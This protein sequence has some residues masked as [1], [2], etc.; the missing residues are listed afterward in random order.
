MSLIATRFFLLLCSILSAGIC[1]GQPANDDCTGFYDLDTLPFC[2]GLVF[3]NSNAL[4]SAISPVNIPSCFSGSQA[5]DDVWFRFVASDTIDDYEFTISGIHN[6]SD[7]AMVNPHITLYRGRCPDNMAELYCRATLDGSNTLKDNLLGLTRGSV[8]Y[9]RV[10]TDKTA[11]NGA[12][13][14]CIR[15]KPVILSIDEGMTD[16]CSG[17]LYD[18]GGETGNYAN[19]ENF[20]FLIC[21][22]GDPACIRLTVDYYNLEGISEFK[23]S[24]DDLRIYKGKETSGDLLYQAPGFSTDSYGAVDIPLTAS[25]SCVTVAFSS[26]SSLTY[27]GFRITWECSAT[28]CETPQTFT[29]TA[30]ENQD[31]IINTI[32][33]ES[34]NLKLTNIKC[35]P[36]AYGLF[37]DKELTLG[38][39]QGLLMTTG[40]AY[41]ARGSNLH[42]NITADLGLEG[43]PDLDKLSQLSGD[44]VKSF[45]ACVLEFEVYA[46]TDELSFDYVFGSDEYP[47]FVDLNYN[48]IFAFLISGPGIA[49]VPELNNQKNIA[50]I[51]LSGLPVEINSVNYHKNWM[52]YKEIPLLS[53]LTEYDGITVNMRKKNKTFTA[54]SKVIP[55]NTYKLKLAIADR[56]DRDYD[57]GVFISKIKGHESEI[58][59]EGKLK[60]LLKNCGLSDGKVRITLQTPAPEDIT[61]NVN[62]SGS[63]I[64]DVDYT[65][66]LGS[67][68][69]FLKN[70]E[71]LVFDLNPIFD[72]NDYQTQVIE[73]I[74]SR[75]FGCGNVIL[76]KKEI[77][78]RGNPDIKIKNKTTGDTLRIC[79][80]DTIQLNATDIGTGSYVWSP[81]IN[82]SGANI[83]NPLC[84]PSSPGWYYVTGTLNGCSSRDSVYIVPG[85]PV[86][87]LA[88][89]LPGEICGLQAF[90]TKATATYPGGKFYWK[91]DDL[92]ITNPYNESQ[93]F[94]LYYG[95]NTFSIEYNM[96]G[97]VVDTS[98]TT[99]VYKYENNFP[100]FT[101]QEFCKG[102]KFNVMFV[103]LGDNQYK[104]EPSDGLYRESGYI[105]GKADHDQTWKLISFIPGSACADTF[106]ISIKVTE[107]N[108]A[109]DMPDQVNLCLGDSLTLKSTGNGDI[110][111]WTDESGNVISDSQNVTIIPQTGIYTITQTK[112]MCKSSKSVTVS[113]DSLPALS[114]YA[115]PV[116]SLY[117][118][119]EVVEVKSDPYNEQEFGNIGFRWLPDDGSLLLPLNGRDN[120]I[121]SNQSQWYYRTMTKGACKSTDSIFLKVFA[122]LTSILGPDTACSGDTIRLSV[123][124][125]DFD[126]IRWEPGGFSST[127]IVTTL[128]QTTPYT[129]IL[130]KEGCTDS[131]VHKVTVLNTYQLR[132]LLTPDTSHLSLGGEVT[133]KIWA[134]PQLPDATVYNWYLDGTLQNNHG[135]KISFVMDKNIKNIEAW[136][137]MDTICYTP[138][139]H[140]LTSYEDLRPQF[141]NAFTPGNRDGVND[142]FRPVIFPGDSGNIIITEFKIFS[143][144]GEKIYDDPK[145]PGWDGSFNGKS[146]PSD[147]YVYKVRWKV[148][149]KSEEKELRGE[150]TLLR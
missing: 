73:I 100:L 109:L 92:V 5:P 42:S 65:T 10:Y 97:C 74:L 141:P 112:G 43:D 104:W 83:R 119:R 120:N 33:S 124:T 28:N 14:L 87:N 39:E 126:S 79:R 149:G 8:Y 67:S 84:Y 2:S 49:G 23:D 96:D 20:T 80:G 53:K 25:S 44:T 114:L 6:G 140:I 26:D 66:N 89:A 138:V 21:P 64:K 60:Y 136:P 95:D 38:L 113:L 9:I 31:E 41:F 18:S 57:S 30:P 50:T 132:I 134:N 143:R 55:C 122:G 29:V 16:E 86:I 72:P 34:N 125:D 77:E 63:A 52:Y 146:L 131:V 147:L 111:K 4:P 69:T 54:T 11:N 98:F 35:D 148:F 130:Y 3:S 75:D 115:D 59:F 32:K 145:G 17:V 68:V 107:N 81:A 121:L 37:K 91:S 123:N 88:P 61:F 27:Q 71:S 76:V 78:L 58:S 128:F 36:R 102:S 46:A 93:V 7:P 51:P 70:Q 1:L 106:L 108:L 94:D 48:D 142:L 19:N 15:K 82:L 117:C 139:F 99:T 45:D 103:G 127:D 150:I 62:L 40:Y 85:L 56:N 144:W 13:T 47:D 116:K 12:F 22:K 135:E 110:V 105:K 24:W 90:E 129:T 137:A 118:K 133:A 101:E